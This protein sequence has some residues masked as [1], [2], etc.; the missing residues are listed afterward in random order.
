M[1]VIVSAGEHMYKCLSP[2]MRQWEKYCGW[3]FGLPIFDSLDMVVCGFSPV[4]FYSSNRVKFHSLGDYNDWPAE[5]W[6]DML[7]KILNDVADE[8]FI[9]M[10]EDYWL[11]RQV[12]IYAVK[13]LFDYA[14]QYQNVLKIDL[15]Y[16]RLYINGGADF[17]YGV[18]TYDHCGYLDLLKSPPGTPYQMSLWGGIWNREQLKRVLV[19]GETPQ[20]IEI[21]GSSRVTDD[22]LVLGTRQG[23]MLHANIY[24]SR[25]AGRPVYRDRSWEIKTEDLAFMKARGWIE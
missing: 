22:Q 18:N 21:A 23:P 25:N 20:D 4:D 5:R 14:A 1:Q 13:M 7:T 24:Q 9:L 2:F 16:D 11:L 17:L 15:G 8:Q 6:S 12:D 3:N 19:P 10:L